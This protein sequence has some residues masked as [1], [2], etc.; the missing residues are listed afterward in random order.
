MGVVTYGCVCDMWV[1][2][3]VVAPHLEALFLCSF[4]YTHPLFPHMSH[5]VSPHMCEMKFFFFFFFCRTSRGDEAE[6][7]KNK[8]KFFFKIEKWP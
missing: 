2:M 3:G 4:A 1:E 6:E 8:K 7:K 5:P